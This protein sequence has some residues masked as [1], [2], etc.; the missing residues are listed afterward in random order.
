M[1]FGRIKRNNNNL[2]LI[3]PPSQCQ[4][5][6]SEQVL[7]KTTL[8]L[9]GKDGEVCKVQQELVRERQGF[10]EMIAKLELQLEVSRRDEDRLAKQ[11]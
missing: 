1:C 6:V 9:E 5:L 7:H 4:Q 2:T 10:E 3:H 8:Q 11:L